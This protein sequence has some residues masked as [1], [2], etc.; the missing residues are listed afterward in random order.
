MATT[1]L[2]IKEL[3]EKRRAH[4]RE[5]KDERKIY[6]ENRD[7][8]RKDHRN[9]LCLIIDGMDQLK[10]D[11]PG[12]VG[13][14]DRDMDSP[15]LK[16]RVIGV[17]VHGHGIYYYV[18][19]AGVPHDS[20]TTLS[21]ILRTLQSVKAKMGMLPPNIWVQMD[22]THQD[23]KSKVVMSAGALFVEAGIT[24]SLTFGFLPV[25]HTHED[26]DQCFSTLA[27]Y[28]K[29]NPC[30]TL[31]QLRRACIACQKGHTSYAEI[32]DSTQVISFRAMLEGNINKDLLIG[33]MQ[34]HNIRWDTKSIDADGRLRMLYKEWMRQEDWIPAKHPTELRPTL[35]TTM[36]PQPYSNTNNILAI[37]QHV[38]KKFS[39]GTRT[40]L[41]KGQKPNPL[42]RVQRD[43]V[44]KAIAFMERGTETVEW[45]RNFYNSEMEKNAKGCAACQTFHK[46]VADNGPKHALSK[47]QNKSRT[48]TQKRARE[49]LKL[50]LQTECKADHD[51]KKRKKALGSQVL[52]WLKLFRAFGRTQA[53]S[54]AESPS[55]RKVNNFPK[56]SGNVQKNESSTR[57]L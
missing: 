28:L 30:D 34:V 6:H 33:L 42:S 12:A 21:I 32:F 40:Q 39:Q 20:D 5:V 53:R 13:T 22:N 17:K 51:P 8:A 4:Y 48:Q 25:G 44:N 2:D 29:K 41:P 54:M 7:R 19:P 49:S 35:V 52:Q 15:S 24:S 38:E 55:E 31:E 14:R 23:N 9:Y 26:I 47:D 57:F 27:R 37:V 36:V 18:I 43:A 50:H 10:T 11:C 1:S 56:F 46:T 16:T 3:R 45:W